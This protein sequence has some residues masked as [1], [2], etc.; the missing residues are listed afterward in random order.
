MIYMREHINRSQQS[1]DKRESHGLVFGHE[2]NMTSKVESKYHKLFSYSIIKWGI[3]YLQGVFLSSFPS[4]IIFA[5]QYLSHLPPSVSSHKRSTTFHDSTW[6]E[7]LSF[8][9]PSCRNVAKAMW[10]WPL[11]FSL[12]C[13]GWEHQLNWESVNVKRQPRHHRWP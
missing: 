12:N 11:D 8:S 9:G 5:L 1:S 6:L 4:W 7:F 3:I 13:S 2:L 10:W